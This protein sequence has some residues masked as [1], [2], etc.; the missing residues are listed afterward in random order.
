MPE[1]VASDVSKRDPISFITSIR[2]RITIH[3][4]RIAALASNA[5]TSTA[6]LAPLP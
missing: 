6:I 3:S 1:E 5:A 4:R 2:S